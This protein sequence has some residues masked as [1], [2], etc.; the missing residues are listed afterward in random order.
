MQGLGSSP[1]LEEPIVK[2]RMFTPQDPEGT[3][4]VRVM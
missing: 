4:T 2:K 3:H 1:K